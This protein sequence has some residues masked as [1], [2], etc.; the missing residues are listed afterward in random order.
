MPWSETT[1]MR[2]RMRF[3]VDAEGELFTMTELCER[4]GISRMTGHKWLRRFRQ[5]GVGA[6]E[7]RCR[8]PLHCPH[9]TDPEVVEAL[10]EARH[11][12]PNWGARKLILW[13]ARR[14]PGLRLPAASTAGDIL[15]RDRRRRRPLSLIPTGPPPR[16]AG[17]R[18]NKPISKDRPPFSFRGEAE[19][20]VRCTRGLGRLS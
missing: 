6:L 19:E 12:H 9:R 13:L 10:V 5:D 11:Q 18:Q 17:F 3:V 2:E 4:Y 16:P 20:R 7:N 8:A 14:Q 1:K 15:V